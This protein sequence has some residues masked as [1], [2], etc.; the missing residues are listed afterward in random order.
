MISTSSTEVIPILT[1]FKFE[2]L[3]MYIHGTVYWLCIVKVQG[4]TIATDF[5]K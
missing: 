3:K 2:N 1:Y 4:Q 5:N